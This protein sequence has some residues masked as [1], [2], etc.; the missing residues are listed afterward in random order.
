MLLSL[1]FSLN[2]LKIPLSNFYLIYII[3]CI[4]NVNAN[5]DVGVLLLFMCSFT[6][7]LVFHLITFRNANEDLDSISS[8]KQKCVSEDEMSHADSSAFNRKNPAR[9]SNFY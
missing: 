1:H 6:L 3:I 8:S 5:S 9:K 2:I 4:G 7:F